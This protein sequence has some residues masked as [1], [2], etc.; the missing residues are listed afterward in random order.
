[1]SA[2]L[3][4]LILFALPGFKARE[5]N[6]ELVR[7]RLLDQIVAEIAEDAA[8][9]LLHLRIER[10]RLIVNRARRPLRAIIAL[11]A[12][13]CAFAAVVG[14]PAVVAVID[15]CALSHS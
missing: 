10:S 12:G 8:E 1:M 15:L 14:P 7:D 2:K 3:V 6:R 9:L 4:S 13:R 11:P 5:K